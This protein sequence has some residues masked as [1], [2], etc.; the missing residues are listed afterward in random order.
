MGSVTENH[1]TQ[2][3]LRMNRCIF[4]ISLSLLS[5]LVLS[6]PTP[7]LSCTPGGPCQ[8]DNIPQEVI[9]FAKRKL[10]LANDGLLRSCAISPVEGTF[11]Q[12]VVAGTIFRFDLKI[13]NFLGS[14]ETCATAPET[15]H[16]VVFKPPTENKNLQVLVGGDDETRC[17][18]EPV[19]SNGYN[20]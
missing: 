17:V 8:A 11:S 10:K 4:V 9:E 6:S 14:Q 18:R 16:M 2:N 7:E 19:K 15:C 5:A 12:Q 20:E 1:R 13:Q 3:L